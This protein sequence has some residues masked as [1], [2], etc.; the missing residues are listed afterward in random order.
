MF[1]VTRIT[2]IVRW[3][4]K[5][6]MII[7]DFGKLGY[8]NIRDRDITERDTTEGNLYGIKIVEIR[9]ASK[10]GYIRG[11]DTIGGGYK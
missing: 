9:P 10:M 7:I 4:Y 5:R 2:C 11:W 6:V 1:Y 8:W 3:G